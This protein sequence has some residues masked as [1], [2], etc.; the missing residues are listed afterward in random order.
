M[1]AYNV[2]MEQNT[3]FV[4]LTDRGYFPRARKTIR[5]L[6]TYGQWNGT[7]VLIVVD[8]MPT[9]EEVTGLGPNFVCL[10]VE[11][12]DHKDLWEIWKQH[13]IRHQFDNS[14]YKK[15]YQWDKFYTFHPFFKTWE[16]IIFIDAG[17]R[18]CRSVEPLLNLDYKGK[19][20]AP[21][22]SDP[23]DNGNR[24]A[25]QFDFDTNPNATKHFYNRFGIDC[26]KEH[27][28]LDC[29]FIFDTELIYGMDTFETLKRWMV[30]FPISCRNDMGIINLYFHI[31]KRVWTP[32]T[33]CLS[34]GSG[35]YFG[36]NESNYRERPS[37]DRFIVMKYPSHGPPSR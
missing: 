21:D 15:F 1:L 11:H 32:L 16:R 22:D 23:Y 17:A 28:F 7:V 3:A 4:T 37:S 29:F 6:R 34:D 26:L 30:E 35:Y 13:P 9:L 25:V 5:D 2:D 8:F 36:W 27:Y 19:L 31:H 18:V 20:L 33:Q 14:Q 12:I 10:P 24:L